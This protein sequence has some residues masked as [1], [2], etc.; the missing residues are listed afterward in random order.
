MKHLLLLLYITVIGFMH[1]Q[2]LLPMFTVSPNPIC[3]GQQVQVTDISQGNPISWSYSVQPQGLGPF[4]PPPTTFAVQNPSFVF[5]Q[6]GTYTISLI[7][8]N[9]NQS[10]PKYS[11]TFTVLQG[12]NANITPNNVNTC[13]GGNA[14][15][16]NVQTGGGGGVG[17]LSYSWSNGSTTSSVS[18]NP[19]VNTVYTCV[20]SATNGCTLIRTASV[21][22][23]NPSVSITGIPS[24]IC[25]GNPAFLLANTSGPAPYTYTWSNNLGNASSI[26]TS[27]AGVYQVTVTNGLNCTGTQSYT[28]I[29]SP[30]ISISAVSNPSVL[31]QGNTATITASGAATYTWDNSSN[32]Q[33]ITV[34]P[35]VNTTYTVVGSYAT[36]NGTAII[37]ISTAI[38]PTL[39][40]SSST[41]NFCRGQSA[42]LSIS[43]ASSY[44]W[45]APVNATG[46]SV[47]VSPNATTTYSVRGANPG[48][49]FKTASISINV[50]PSPVIQVSSNYTQVCVGEPVALVA[51]GA[52]TY[53]WNTGLN[54]AIIIVTPTANTVYSVSS[55]NINGCSATASINI[56]ASICE[57][58]TQNNVSALKLYPQ[59]AHSILY[60]DSPLKGQITLLDLQGRIHMQMPLEIGPNNLTLEGLQAGYYLLRIHSEMG[61]QHQ[62]I[63]IY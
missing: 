24:S 14:V 34:S 19:T 42:T 51:S 53:T 58:L 56:I 1:A 23:S 11:Q 35:T 9:G 4:A 27:I 37:T 48:C 10:S 21:S 52:N 20:I 22:V 44:S 18:V 45:Q 41:N 13:I 8:S 54:T 7:I 29:S 33:I 60:L 6:P 63:Y 15:A 12:P 61:L 62:R 57:G 49:P 46:S 26:S 59:P 36:C 47:V 32:S 3:T 43:G 55:Q 16:L 38:N 39:S 50:L 40:I 28:L 17:P 2:N 31:C 5:N 30:N 25:P